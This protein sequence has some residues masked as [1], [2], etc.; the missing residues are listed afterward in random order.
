[1]RGLAYGAYV[2]GRHVLDRLN[3]GS[4][5]PMTYTPTGEPGHHN[6]DP[7][8]PD[9]GFLGPQWGDV[10]PFAVQG[11]EQFM[12]DPPPAL[13]GAEYTAVFNEVK[14]AGAADAETSDRDGNG[15]PDRTPE[16][17]EIGLFWGYDGSP[18]LGTPPRLYFQIAHALAVRQGHT[19]AETARMFALLGLAQADAGIVCWDD[20]Y[21]HD[22]WRPILGVR[23]A[24]RDGNPDTIAEA[25]WAPLGARGAT[26]P[27]RTRTSRRTSRPTP[28][29]TPPS[30]PPPSA[31]W[32]TSTAPTPSPAGR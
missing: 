11:A 2:G 19:M 7:L 20:K 30:V 31:P 22:F 29:G 28:R 15:Q 25:D 4:S 17:T 6:V 1:M 10:R 18:G 5:A 23:E 8:H 9:Q 24:D 16:Q 12:I 21:D 3:D 26:T 13:T 27:D 32:P 14:V